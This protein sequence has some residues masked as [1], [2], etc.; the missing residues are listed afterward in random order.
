MRLSLRALR[1]RWY[2]KY[3][4]KIVKPTRYIFGFISFI[5]FSQEVRYRFLLRFN[6]E[7]VLYGLALFKMMYEGDFVYLYVFMLA[8]HFYF[9]FKTSPCYQFFFILSFSLRNRI[10][11]LSQFLS[12]DF[13]YFHFKKA[14]KRKNSS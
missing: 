4:L 13:K 1:W 6:K 14:K 3:N 5:Y 2:W 8:I 9:S 7:N 10:Q 11:Y 12:I